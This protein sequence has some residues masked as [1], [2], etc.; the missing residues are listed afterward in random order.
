MVLELFKSEHE[1]E[2]YESFD[3]FGAIRLLHV[4]Y[5]FDKCVLNA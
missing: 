1:S 5:R 3:L 2:K 4:K